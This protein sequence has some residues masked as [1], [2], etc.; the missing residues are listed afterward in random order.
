MR[1]WTRSAVRVCSWVRDWKAAVVGRGMESERVR[2][3]GIRSSTNSSS[4]GATRGLKRGYA[5]DW[6]RRV[7]WWRCVER[8]VWA[9]TSLFR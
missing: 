8:A 3:R 2:R 6:R 7:W 4:G 1:V 9:V 5:R